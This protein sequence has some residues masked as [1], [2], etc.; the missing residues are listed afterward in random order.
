MDLPVSRRNFLR[1][2]G[3]FALLACSGA[4]RAFAA[5]NNEHFA[6]AYQSAEGRYGV[7]VFTANGDLIRDI[8]L[9]GRGHDVT[10]SPQTGHCVAFARRPGNFAVIFDIT[11]TRPPVTLTSAPGRHFYGHGVF[12]PDGQL[13]YTTENDFDAGDG[14]IGIY[15]C[16]GGFRRIGEMPSHGVG[17]HQLALMGDGTTLVIASG[18]IETHPDF[19]RR[20]LNLATMQPGIAFIDRTSGDLLDQQ[21][22]P[23]DL[24]QLSLRHLA[25]APD[26]TVWLGGQYEGPVTDQPPLVASLRRDGQINMIDLPDVTAGLKNYI[27]SV[28]VSRDGAR[29]ATSAPRGDKVLIWSARDRRVIREIPVAAGCGAAPASGGFVLSGPTGE[30]LS[31]GTGTGQQISGHRWD[32]HI[33]RLDG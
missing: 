29:V 6:A 26:Q 10:L 12:S 15:D 11:G 31:T 16:M 22:L 27:G 5:T 24:H 20:K 8:D 30:I 13:L 18:G 4:A 32:N 3:G 33:S 2:T 9:P 14:V 21:R 19:G 1:T 23:A 7:A 25:V 17:P 28:A